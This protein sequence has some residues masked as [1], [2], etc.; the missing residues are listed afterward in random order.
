MDELISVPALLT[1]LPCIDRSPVPGLNACSL[2]VLYHNVKSAPSP[3]VETDC[4]H[5]L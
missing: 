2:S 3:T 4:G 5:V 1:E